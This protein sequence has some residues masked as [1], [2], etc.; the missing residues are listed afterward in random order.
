VFLHS[1]AVDADSRVYVSDTVGHRV[2][3][4]SH[5][6]QF[7]RMWGGGDGSGAVEFPHDLGIDRGGQGYSLDGRRG[8]DTLEFPSALTVD[9][10]GHVYVLDHKRLV[11]FTTDGGTPG[12]VKRPADFHATDLAIDGD[13][14]I[15]LT[16][17]DA[18]RRSSRVR[19]ISPAGT[20][21]L[22][23][24]S[25]GRGDGEFFGRTRMALDPAGRVFLVDWRKCQIE[26]FTS[27]GTF[28]GR[29]GSCGFGEGQFGEA[30]GI[31]VD[32]TG[33]VFVADYTNNRVHVFQVNIR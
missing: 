11:R 17:G 29:W 25:A 20:E 30:S 12:F 22:S 31:A 16:E 14:N 3:V 13:G 4:F 8:A 27:N 5:T 28:L 9:R 18:D 23:W 7:I 26:V 19:I 6:G 2:Q 32:A 21:L 10:A 33:K 24:Q 1:I 15:Y